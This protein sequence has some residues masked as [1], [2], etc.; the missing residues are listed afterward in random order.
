M[1]SMNHFIQ[2]LSYFYFF[3]YI[4]GFM[5]YNYNL[6][7]LS[8]HVILIS[9]ILILITEFVVILLAG[10]HDKSVTLILYN[11]LINN[12]MTNCLMVIFINTVNTK[13]IVFI[14]SL[15]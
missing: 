15:V 12:C 11:I 8:H 7:V 4:Y 13:Y 14:H 3:I 6:N 2:I 1:N 5:L 10:Y 9:Q